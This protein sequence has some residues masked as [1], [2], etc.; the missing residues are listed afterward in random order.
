VIVALAR[1]ASLPIDGDSYTFVPRPG[2]DAVRT[3]AFGH[4]VPGRNFWLWYWVSDEELTVV[5]L[6]TVP[7]VVH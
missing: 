7:P 4:R 1:A 3:L 5:G 6:T 2:D